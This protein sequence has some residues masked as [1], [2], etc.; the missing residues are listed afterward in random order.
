[1]E[2][3]AAEL[4]GAVPPG[5]AAGLPGGECGVWHWDPAPVRPGHLPDL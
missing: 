5:P 2:R 4:R 3:P 1:M